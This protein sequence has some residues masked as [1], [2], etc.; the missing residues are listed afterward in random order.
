MSAVIHRSV[1]ADGP[2]DEGKRKPQLLEQQ[3][4]VVAGTAQHGDMLM[5]VNKKRSR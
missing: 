5:A 3:A 1:A 2:N 4:D